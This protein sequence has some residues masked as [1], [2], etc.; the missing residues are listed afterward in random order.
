MVML[1]TGVFSQ[2]QISKFFV[3]GISDL[4]QGHESLASAVQQVERTERVLKSL[5]LEWNQPK[6]GWAEQYF[7]LEGQSDQVRRTAL[8]VLRS[9]LG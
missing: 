7:R 3:G 1:L 6:P 9:L 2:R 5:W 4:P 8:L